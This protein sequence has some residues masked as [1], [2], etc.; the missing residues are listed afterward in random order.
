[1]Q[2]LHLIFREG[3]KRGGLFFNASSAEKGEIIGRIAVNLIGTKGAVGLT[4]AALKSTINQQ[5]KQ[6]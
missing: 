4:K 3:R 1:M 5:L 6:E 2:L